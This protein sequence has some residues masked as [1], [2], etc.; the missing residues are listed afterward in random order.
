MHVIYD[1]GGPDDCSAAAIAAAGGAYTPKCSN[2]ASHLA[3]TL[4]QN[5]LPAALRIPGA[6]Y[7]LNADCTASGDPELPN[8]ILNG[9]YY[10]GKTG[11]SG[12]I[13]SGNTYLSSGRI[14]PPWHDHRGLAGSARTT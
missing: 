13:P 5:S 11:T 7:C 3:G 12:P 14:D 8:G 1:A 10:A 2:S 4:E 9:T 6:V